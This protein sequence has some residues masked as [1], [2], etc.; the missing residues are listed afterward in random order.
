MHEGKG[1]MKIKTP[2]SEKMSVIRF[3]ELIDSS[4]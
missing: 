3:L 4:F 2:F 1:K